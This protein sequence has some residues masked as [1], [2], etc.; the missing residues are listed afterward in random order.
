MKGRFFFHLL[1][2]KLVAK[3]FKAKMMMEKH[4]FLKY[5]WL[6]EIIRYILPMVLLQKYF[7]TI[8]KDYAYTLK[9]IS[10][11]L[12]KLFSLEK[13]FFKLSPNLLFSLF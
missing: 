13:H 2:D 5:F 8:L 12:K 11:F 7:S 9:S 1:H 10:H 4:C 6:Y 3:D